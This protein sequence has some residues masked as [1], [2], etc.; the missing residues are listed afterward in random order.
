MDFHPDIIPIPIRTDSTVF[1]QGIPWNLTPAE[2]KKIA[3]V[4]HSFER[5]T[6]LPTSRQIAPPKPQPPS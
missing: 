3:N 2:A 5:E 4:I 1:I 6:V